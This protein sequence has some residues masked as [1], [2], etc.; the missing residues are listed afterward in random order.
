MNQQ[1]IRL[2]AVITVLTLAC[3]LIVFVMARK[4][5][6]RTPASL[7]EAQITVSSMVCEGCAQRVTETLTA[8]PG[9]H[10]VQP[11]VGDKRVRVRY[12]PQ[13]IDEAALRAALETAGMTVV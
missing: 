12:A 6:R 3:A 2:L 7:Q 10:S 4:K 1:L 9:V 11:S 5:R 8:V 13:E